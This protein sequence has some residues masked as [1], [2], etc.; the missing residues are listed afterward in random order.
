MK[1]V[2]LVDD[3]EIM[4]RIT[5]AVLGPL[6]VSTEQAEDGL[7]AHEKLSQERFDAMVIDLNMRGMSGLDTIQF[8]RAQGAFPSLFIIVV[9][10]SQREDDIQRVRD[11]GVN[12]F[13]LKSDLHTQLPLEM[14]ALLHPDTS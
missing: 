14:E 1:K 11:L 2:L 4:R 7:E 13:I 9:S 5:Q 10:A 3:S 12:A 6:G 8:I